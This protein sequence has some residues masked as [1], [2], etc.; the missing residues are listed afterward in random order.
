VSA[1]RI[2]RPGHATELVDLGPACGR[3]SFTRGPV[4]P[5]GGMLVVVQ[6]ERT[7]KAEQ[8]RR[9]RAQAAKPTCG[10]WMPIVKEPCGRRP[11]HRDSCRSAVVMADEAKRRWS[12]GDGVR[13]SR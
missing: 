12:G 5:I 6:S 4:A 9:Y 2:A 10:K 7:A 11:G 8:S 13:V 1:L 3:V